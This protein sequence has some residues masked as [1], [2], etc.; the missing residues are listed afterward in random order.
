MTSVR[1]RFAP[2]PTGHLHIGGARTALYAWLFARKH[3]G[4]F[5]LRIEDT[6]VERS[7][8]EYTDAILA[9]MEWLG[10]DFDEGPFYQ[11]QRLDRYQ[12][13]LQQLLSE[14]KAYRCQCSKERLVALREQ[15]LQA[16]LKPRY[17][18]H[19]RQLNL[20]AQDAPFVVRLRNPTE[21]VVSFNDQVR[22]VVTFQNGELDDLILA[23]SDGIPTYNFT[24]VVDDYDMKITHVIRGDDHINNTPR[25]INILYAL[26]VEPP[27]YAHLPMILGPDG[28][29]LSKRHG[30][31][32]VLQYKAEGYLPAA[33]LNYLARLGWSH[34]DQEVFS[35]D[36]LK[37]LFSLTALNKAPA[38]LNPDKLLWLNQYYLKHMDAKVVA[39]LL[40]P[41]LQQLGIDI[42][43]GPDLDEVVEA[44]RERSK[45]LIEM[46]EKSQCFYSEIK[47]F[48]EK[49]VA[50]HL[51]VEA[52]AVLEEV[53]KQLQQL[54]HWDEQ[55]IHQVISGTAEKFA[56]KMGQVAQPIRVA[57][58]GGTVSPPIDATI[59]LIGKSRVLSRLQAAVDLA[60]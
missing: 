2:S 3:N 40:E 50:Q 33:L 27:I 11:T 14:G 4:Q 19:C 22:G 9:S 16:K 41:Y 7:D 20:T 44:Q 5:I 8:T 39:T 25:Q 49:A 38:A 13:V 56:I 37:K 53:G 31:V 42:N 32:S 24:V 21:G 60:Q 17:D 48:D 10:L 58:T 55:S 45:T 35:V 47:T 18:G 34:G 29:R 12:A 6:D 36:E 26:G 46:A 30:A 43:H 51:N 23:R 28:K 59:R 1:T 54:V 57:L 15:Q 52:T